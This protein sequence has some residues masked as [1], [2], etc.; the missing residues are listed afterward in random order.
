M[1]GAGGPGAVE[2]SFK[3][4]E[5]EYTSAARAF[6]LRTPH[7]KFHFYLGAA[8]LVC[9]LL[10]A[11]LAG[12]PYLGATLFVIGLVVM[13]WRYYAEYALPRL[14]FRRN[15]KFRDAYELRFG[16]EGILFRSKGMESRL[17][18]GFYSKVWETP[19]FYYLVYGRDMFSLIPKRAF[20]GGR[21]E[22]AFR[23]LLRRKID[24]EV[25]TGGLPGGQPRGLGGEYV[26][27]PEPPD[28]R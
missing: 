19:D 12:D 4:T 7:T 2:L 10:F 24:P 27:P 15:P 6:Y 21:Q 11:A 18:W 13:A 16:E 3:Y 23:D 22:A 25:G 9:S 5:E 28:W 1:G 17:E 20:R 26:P 8:V 14:H